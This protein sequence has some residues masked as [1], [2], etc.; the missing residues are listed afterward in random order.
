MGGPGWFLRVG[1]EERAALDVKRAEVTS[2]GTR[3][4]TSIFD[5]SPCHRHPGPSRRASHHRAAGRKCDSF[6]F[7]E[8][9]HNVRARGKSVL[10]SLDRPPGLTTLQSIMSQELKTGYPCS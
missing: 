5:E 6:G 7:F 3:W 10:G 1:R 8:F 4:A 9:I 2:P